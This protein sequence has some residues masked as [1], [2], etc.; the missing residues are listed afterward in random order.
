MF[1]I[2]I[3]LVSYFNSKLKAKIPN[4]YN[5]Q[6][7]Q[8]LQFYPINYNSNVLMSSE[9]KY[10]VALKSE[11]MLYYLVLQHIFSPF[12]KTFYYPKYI[13][14]KYINTNEYI[15]QFYDKL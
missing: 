5:L 13:L 1:F 14:L 10:L 3:I 12:I 2:S 6:H 15:K 7:K 4:A 9:N 11:L 8:H